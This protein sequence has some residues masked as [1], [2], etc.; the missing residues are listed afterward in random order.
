MQTVQ[1]PIARGKRTIPKPDRVI[2]SVVERFV[3]IEDAGSSN[4]SSPT[5][6]PPRGTIE[7]HRPEDAESLSN[8]DLLTIKSV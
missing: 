1:L 7:P 6:I 4:L 8:S 3:H 5:R 2:S